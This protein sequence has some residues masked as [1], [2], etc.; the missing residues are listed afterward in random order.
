MAELS[1]AGLVVAVARGRAD[2]LAE[3]YR[4]HGPAVYG[5]AGW[6]C[7][8]GQA[9]EVTRAVFVSLW[10]SPGKFGPGTG[11]LRSLLVAEAHRRAVDLLRADTARR[12]SEAATPADDLEQKILANGANDAIGNLLAGLSRTERQAIILAY[13]GGYTRRQVASLVRRPAQTVNADI[14]S[15]LS[16]LH[17]NLTADGQRPPPGD[18]P[19]QGPARRSSRRPTSLIRTPQAPT[20]SCELSSPMGLACSLPGSEPAG[21]YEMEGLSH[22]EI[23]GRHHRDRP[24]RRRRPRLRPE[25]GWPRS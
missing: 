2:A 9:E 4:R 16:R 14:R 1:D 21:Y 18:Q 23:V 24:G 10:H 11:C 8:P 17:A 12:A 6:L 22:D 3:A 7:G 19:L 25:H 5:L 20:T 13:F 15:G